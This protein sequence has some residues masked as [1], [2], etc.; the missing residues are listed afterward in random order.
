MTIQM[1]HGAQR[2]RP[3]SYSLLVCSRGGFT[4]ES[5]VLARECRPTCAEHD[6]CTA[7]EHML[8]LPM[9]ALALVALA[10]SL[11]IVIMKEES[12][13]AEGRVLILCP[14]KSLGVARP[15]KPVT[16]S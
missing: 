4:S 2:R 6:A 16:I 14:P 1:L 3:A 15:S 9:H 10:K 11:F 13:A 7:Y 8:E 5:W 12:A